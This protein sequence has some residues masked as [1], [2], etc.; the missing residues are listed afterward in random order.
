MAEIV[1]LRMARKAR[2]RR[3]AESKA[4]EARALSGETKAMRDKRRID[5][6]R[7]ARTIDGAKREDTP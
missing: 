3:E 2:S 1:N 5:A 6:E 4:A 7:A